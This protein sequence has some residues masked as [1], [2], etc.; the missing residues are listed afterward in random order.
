M[1]DLA[2]MWLH[3]KIAGEIMTLL[4]MGVTFGLTIWF[5]FH[6]LP[7]VLSSWGW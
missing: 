4:M 1:R 5:L 2:K 3:Y 6:V 7:I